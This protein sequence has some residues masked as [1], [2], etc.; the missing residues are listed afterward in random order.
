MFDRLSSISCIEET[1][2]ELEDLQKIDCGT[3]SMES[4]FQRYFLE[5]EE[6]KAILVQN[7]ASLD[8]SGIPDEI[9][10]QYDSS[11]RILYH[12]KSLFQFWCKMCDSYRQISKLA[13]QDHDPSL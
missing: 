11:A 2:E 9:Q 4:E 3:Q 8:A 7:P 13:F 5:L 1:G 6:Q 12:E 10:D